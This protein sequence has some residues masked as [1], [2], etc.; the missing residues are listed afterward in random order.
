MDRYL[1]SRGPRKTGLKFASS[2][3]NRR[4]PVFPVPAL[5]LGFP[6]VV[7]ELLLVLMVHP[8][9]LLLHPPGK[10]SQA[11]P[12]QRLCEGNTRGMSSPE[13]AG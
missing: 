9:Y 6:L 5:G 4:E 7:V 3:L 12:L 11:S 10:L 13:R 2:L 8:P 1:A